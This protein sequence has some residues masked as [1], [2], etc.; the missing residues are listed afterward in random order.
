MTTEERLLRLENSFSSLSELAA[1]SEANTAQ[2]IEL[3]RNADERMDDHEKW[4]NELGAA[5]ANSEARIAALAD[6]QIKTEAVITSLGQKVDSLAQQVGE[7]TA[8]QSAT[9]RRLNALID[10]LSK[11]GNSLP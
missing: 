9:D 3:A 4:I 1:K 11:F 8:A 7:L 5:Q 6:A 10:G 2:L